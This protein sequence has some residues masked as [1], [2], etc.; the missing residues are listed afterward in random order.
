MSWICSD[1]DGQVAAFAD[2]NLAEAEFPYV[3]LDATYCKAR[4]GGGMGGKG[5]RVASQAVV[6]ANG[7]SADGRREVLGFAVGDSEDGAFWTAFPG[8]LKAGG[9]HGVKLA[10]SGAH[11][12]LKAAVA[13]V[14]IGSTRQWCRVHFL[15]QHQTLPFGTSAPP[16]SG[17][18]RWRT[19]CAA[20]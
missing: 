15:L 5:C 7:V 16:R 12:G 2:R 18:Q 14:M 10:V 17:T 13:A 3:F 4:V 1:L 6:V 11:T 9:L 20:S 19:R 8:S